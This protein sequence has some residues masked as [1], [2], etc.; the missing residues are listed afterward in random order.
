M[1]APFKLVNESTGEER[2]PNCGRPSRCTWAAFC[3][4]GRIR[5]RL[6]PVNWRAAL[7]LTM[8]AALGVPNRENIRTQSKAWSNFLKLLRRRFGAFDFAFIREHNGGR[9]HLN[10]I[11]TLAFVPDI[12]SL[13]ER[14]GF[15]KIIS[16]RSLWK[17]EQGNKTINYFTK[18]LALTK[19]D[20][21][22]YWPPKTR[23][24]QTSISRPTAT[25]R[26]RYRRI[27]VPP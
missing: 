25:K 18:Y 10:V 23:R 16:V 19:F 20:E 14:A 13:A 7:V 11:W 17:P 22:G 4:R 6:Y 8:P 21:D 9:L 15:G 12:S 3:Y 2:R 1:L 5:N 24:V 27:P 26:T